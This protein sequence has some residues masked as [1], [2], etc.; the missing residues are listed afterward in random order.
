[1]MI[2]YVPPERYRTNTVAE[3]DNY[4]NS[5]CHTKVQHVTKHSA[6]HI[7]QRDAPKIQLAHR[8]SAPSNVMTSLKR[9]PGHLN[10]RPMDGIIYMV[11]CFI[12]LHI[13]K[14]IFTSARHKFQVY[15]H[16]FISIMNQ[17]ILQRYMYI[18][19]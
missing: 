7:I 14:V 10:V 4:H 5:V 6:C 11:E 8:N 18:I 16:L 9:T 13:R 17:F 12:K 15:H 3:K 1:M 2:L 19:I